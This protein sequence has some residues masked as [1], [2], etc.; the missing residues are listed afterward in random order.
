MKLAL[1]ELNNSKYKSRSQYIRII[2]ETWLKNEMYCPVC[3]NVSL[4]KLK[5]NAKMADFLCKNCGEIYELK[6]KKTPPALKIIDGSYYAALERITSNTN[7]NLLVLTYDSKYIIDN[8]TVI[9]KYFL[10][11]DILL[12]RKPLSANARRAGY[13]GCFIQYGMIVNYGKISIVKSY[14]EEDKNVVLDNYKSVSRLEIESINL[15]GWI[16]DI[17]KCVD[18]INQN[19]FSLNDLY[20]FEHELEQKHPDNRNIRAKIRQ[21]IQFLRNKGF[22][23][24]LGNGIYR[25]ILRG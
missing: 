25:K 12:K 5:N 7:P 22:I 6:S 18:K 13:V 24:F 14:I 1:P 2:T 21:Q 23:E 9:P 8:L 17:L 10:T 4:S 20:T 3:G 19:I 16:M 15:R 11:P